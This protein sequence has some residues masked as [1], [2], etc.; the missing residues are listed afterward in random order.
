[1]LT[2]IY[3]IVTYQIKEKLRIRNSQIKKMQYLLFAYSLYNSNSPRRDTIVSMQ[4]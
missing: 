3:R 1:M 4:V 2:R